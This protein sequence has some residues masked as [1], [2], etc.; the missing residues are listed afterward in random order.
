[1]NTV[2]AGPAPATQTPGNL[3]AARVKAQIRN[4]EF[5]Y[6]DFKAL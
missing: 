5:Y 2:L 1:M 4:V 6:N 3:P